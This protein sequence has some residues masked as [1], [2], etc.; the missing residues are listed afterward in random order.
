M[1]RTNPPPVKIP[2]KILADP[3][4]RQ[5]FLDLTKSLYLIWKHSRSAD[6][7]AAK[8]TI[9][10]TAPGTPDFAIQN[11]SAGGFG[12]ATAD[13]GNTVLQVVANLQT[14][15]NEIEDHLTGN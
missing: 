8:T 6:L 11:L 13:E 5:F 12:F 4:L 15:V 10:H 2:Q 9:T 3:E 7:T 14:R 1:S